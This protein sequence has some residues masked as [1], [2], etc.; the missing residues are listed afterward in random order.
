MFSACE[1]QQVAC[2][3]LLSHYA[4]KLLPFYSN[5]SNFLSSH[6]KRI[7]EDKI[8][9]T[10]FLSR[11]LSHRRLLHST[12]G[13]KLSSRNNFSCEERKKNVEMKK[14]SG[15]LYECV[16]VVV[17]ASKSLSLSLIIQWMY[18][19]FFSILIFTKFSF[20]LQEHF[21]GHT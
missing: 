20:F 16:F 19:Y 10:F 9:L 21:S 14:S 6:G 13:K 15:R 3:L 1:N 18:M 4:R 7:L 5:F 8:L 11:P 2:F 17:V 12:T